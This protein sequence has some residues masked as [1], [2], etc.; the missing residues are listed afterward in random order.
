MPVARASFA[1]QDFHARSET[2]RL[3][4]IAKLS[5]SGS[6]SHSGPTAINGSSVAI[7]T[8]AVAP[9]EGLPEGL[10]A[11]G[12][13]VGGTSTISRPPSIRQLRAKKYGPETG[14]RL[15]SLVDSSP[16]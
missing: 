4:P 8:L 13:A 16:I 11:G 15:S 6:D 9:V 14:A 5:V 1:P 2:Q 12:A 7:T 3:E 10:L